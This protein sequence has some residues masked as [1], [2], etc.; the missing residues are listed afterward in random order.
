MSRLISEYSVKLTSFKILGWIMVLISVL[1]IIDGMSSGN[2]DKITESLTGGIVGL[3]ISGVF[4]YFGKKTRTIRIFSDGI[5]YIQS[6]KVFSVEWDN[7]A[8]IKTFRENGKQSENLVI[9]TEDEQLINISSAYFDKLKLS[10]AFND[11]VKFVNDELTLNTIT[12]E[13]D[14]GWLK[15]SS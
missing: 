4:F 13:D 1:Y 14:C 15:E 2:Q 6:N 12:I 7:I 10:A 11:I 9:M 5:E 3:L 8:L